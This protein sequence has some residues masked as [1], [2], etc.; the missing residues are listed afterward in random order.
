MAKS[1]EFTLN[2][3]TYRQPDTKKN[4]VYKSTGNTDKNGEPIM[5]R[6]AMK[7][8]N[9]AY[10]KWEAENNDAWDA[11]DIKQ[12]RDEQQKI[13][14]KQAEEAFNKSKKAKKMVGA[15]VKAK[16]PRKSKDIA[17]EHKFENGIT[18]TLTAKQVDFI[19]HIPDTSFYENGTDSTVWC[20]ILADEIGGKFE[21]KPM[22]VGAMI[23][24]LREKN[25][26]SVGVDK[27]RNG[28][29]AKFFEFTEYGKDIAKE[30]GLK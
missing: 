4:Y 2:N 29:K 27:D 26:I 19:H 14:D 9:E 13:L 22:T 12:Y 5:M 11:E 20:D 18:I 1:I 28:R 3:V 7:V 21:G 10:A 25:V 8:F 23:S 16:K 24:T 17:F 15:T 30:L 6:I